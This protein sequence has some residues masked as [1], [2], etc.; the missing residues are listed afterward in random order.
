[1]RQHGT[2]KIKHKS[3]TYQSL[4][5]GPDNNI[6]MAPSKLIIENI[7]TD[8]D[9]NEYSLNLFHLFCPKIMFVI[10]KFMCLHL[11]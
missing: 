3:Q 7:E 2:L 10:L 9:N 4:L 11:F 5:M 8:T 1:M 6:H